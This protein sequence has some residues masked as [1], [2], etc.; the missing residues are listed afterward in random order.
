MKTHCTRCGTRVIPNS[1]R[2]V[3]IE[4]ETG[5]RRY[6]CR[7]VHLALWIADGDGAT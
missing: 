2:Y 4:E 6:F 7:L 5:I 1:D 3:L